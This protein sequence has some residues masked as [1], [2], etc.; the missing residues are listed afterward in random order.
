M[1]DLVG[2]LRAANQKRMVIW[3]AALI[4]EAADRIE[5]LE[6][7]VAELEAVGD[8]AVKALHRRVLEAK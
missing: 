7:Q 2:R 8:T 1:S 4:N 5:A 6:R 3:P